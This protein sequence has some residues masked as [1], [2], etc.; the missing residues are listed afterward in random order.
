VGSCSTQMGKMHGNDSFLCAIQ[1]RLL[2]GSDRYLIIGPFID[3]LLPN[4]E[5]DRLR[6]DNL[7]RKLNQFVLLLRELGCSGGVNVLVRGCPRRSRA[8]HE[9]P[10]QN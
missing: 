4:Q 9:C 10:P 6:R 5:V 8:E 1:C 2:N 3:K 7:L